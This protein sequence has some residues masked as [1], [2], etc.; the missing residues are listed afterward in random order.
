MRPKPVILRAGPFWVSAFGLTTS[1]GETYQEELDYLKNWTT[2]RLTWL[3]ENLPEPPVVVTD[4]VPP[5]V[6]TDSVPTDSVPPTVPTD[7][8]TTDPP[9]ADSV[10]TS[11]DREKLS[12]KT[13]MVYPNPFGQQTD[14]SVHPAAGGYHCRFECTTC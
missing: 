8:V 3:D 13:P 4:P 9:P 12:D 7:T 1:V 10:V 2:Q 6:P 11:I 14:D 5:T